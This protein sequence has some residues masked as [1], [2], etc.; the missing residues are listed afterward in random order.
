MDLY[1]Y[2][3]QPIQLKGDKANTQIQ[4]FL[5]PNHNKLSPCKLNPKEKR[6]IY[7]INYG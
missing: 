6:Q 1:P 4:A 5:L 7:K 3:Y 2:F